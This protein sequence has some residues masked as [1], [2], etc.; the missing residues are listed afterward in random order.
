[1]V[2]SENEETAFVKNAVE[3]GAMNVHNVLHNG[4]GMLNKDKLS[5][6]TNKGKERERQHRT[7]WRQTP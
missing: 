7:R 4:T 2:Q 1:M 6:D 5:T 3:A